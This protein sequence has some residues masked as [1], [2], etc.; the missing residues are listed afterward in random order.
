VLT[1]TA[2]VVSRGRVT[3]AGGIDAAGSGDWTVAKIN[4]GEYE[5]KWNAERSSAI[6]A[7]V[8]TSFTSVVIGLVD[9]SE[10]TAKAFKVR[11][12]TSAG[13]QPNMAF[14]FVAPPP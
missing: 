1:R 10:T 3:A 6:Y 11:T 5:V 2:A 9:V 14:S 12:F 7:V 8:A 13:A 4:T